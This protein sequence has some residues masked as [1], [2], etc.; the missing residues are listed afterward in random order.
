MTVRQQLWLKHYLDPDNPATFLSLGGAAKA[1]GYQ[2]SSS[3]NHNSV[4]RA[5]FKALGPKISTWLDE[6][7]M[8]EAVLKK[9]LLDL[10]SAKE[11]KLVKIKGAVDEWDLAPDARIVA[12]SKRETVLAIELDAIDQQRRALDMALKM[13]GLYKADNVQKGV[14]LEQVIDSISVINPDFALQ[15]RAELGKLASGRN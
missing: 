13:K 12:Q 14:S 10:L 9:Q 6:S 3:K 11:I 15:V 5:V 7:G 4:G 8:S 1:A 2:A